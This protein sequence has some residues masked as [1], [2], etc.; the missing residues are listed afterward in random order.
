MARSSKSPRT[1][2]SFASSALVPLE[3]A[4]RSALTTFFRS[5]AR[6]TSNTPAFVVTRPPSALP[7]EG[8]TSTKT[9]SLTGL[10]YRLEVRQRSIP[11]GLFHEL[12]GN[13]EP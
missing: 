7:S 4:L 9:F 3:T 11:Q 5:L 13:G 1:L 2:S 10:R 6:S 8:G 12:E